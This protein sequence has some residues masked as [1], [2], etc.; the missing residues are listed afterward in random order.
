MNEFKGRVE[1]GRKHPTHNNIISFRYKFDMPVCSKE[2][3][4][5]YEA[6]RRR[7]LK[8]LYYAH[9]QG[10]TT[11]KFYQELAKMYNRSL[12]FTPQEI[13]YDPPLWD[14]EITP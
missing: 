13:H 6:Q 14:K 1:W 8:V 3:Y 11:K 12:F 7:H 5:K 10:I 9:T 4:L 2:E